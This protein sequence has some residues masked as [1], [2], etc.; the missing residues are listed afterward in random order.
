MG[1]SDVDVVLSAVSRVD[2]KKI[3]DASFVEQLIFALR[4]LFGDWEKDT[5]TDFDNWQWIIFVLMILVNLLVLSNFVISIIN[6]TY[7]QVRENKVQNF[8]KQRVTVVADL[9]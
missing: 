1:E 9:L 5:L 7:E 4:A 8:F 3:F 2:T 6:D